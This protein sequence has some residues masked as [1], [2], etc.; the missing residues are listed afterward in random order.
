MKNEIY[1]IYAGDNLLTDLFNKQHL[2]FLNLV[3]KC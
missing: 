2:S 1:A 3:F